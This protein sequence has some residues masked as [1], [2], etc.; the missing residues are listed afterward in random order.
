MLDLQAIGGLWRSASRI[1]TSPCWP[2][3]LYFLGLSKQRNYSSKEPIELC[4]CRLQ[5][6]F[7]TGAE[8]YVLK[9]EHTF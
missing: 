5:Q 9:H 2:P 7:C 6:K 4:G 1:D 8:H 3:F